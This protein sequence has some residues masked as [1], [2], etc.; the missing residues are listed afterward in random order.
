[1]NAR[2]VWAWERL[3]AVFTGRELPSLNVI[4]RRGWVLGKLWVDKDGALAKECLGVGGCGRIMVEHLS[5]VRVS[6]DTSCGK[7]S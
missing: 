6:S 1:M 5:E 3:G 7:D 2:C 4:R